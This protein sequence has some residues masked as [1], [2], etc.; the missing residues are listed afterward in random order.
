[1]K[2]TSKI[3]AAAVAAIAVA[4]S[5][6]AATTGPGS[7]ASSSVLLYVWD[8]NVPAGGTVGQGYVL[9][10]GLT[11][12]QLQ[13]DS[14]G[15]SYTT[16]TGGSSLFESLFSSSD[17]AA[18]DVEFM[19]VSGNEQVAPS[20]AITSTAFGTAPNYKAGQTVL[21]NILGYSDSALQNLTPGSNESAISGNVAGNGNYNLYL[22]ANNSQQDSSAD[23]V[24]AAGGTTDSL[25]QAVTVPNTGKGTTHQPIVTNTGDT[26]TLLADGQVTIGAGVSPVP[27]PAA[28]W[29]FGSGLLGLFGFSR[30]RRIG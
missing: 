4:G 18:G 15:A 22:N 5:A 13:S 11:F 7:G 28:V 8:T 2:F 3:I 27:L 14:F 17:I 1:M 9:D 21:N 23:T 19:L 16:N 26:L 10:T 24:L 20:V 25:Y 29:L 30:R 12:A 6:Q